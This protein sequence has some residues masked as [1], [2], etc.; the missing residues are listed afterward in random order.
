MHKIIRKS[1]SFTDGAGAELAADINA[2]IG[3]ATTTA[4]NTSKNHIH[5]GNSGAVKFIGT[6]KTAAN[7]DMTHQR[8]PA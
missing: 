7:I 2:A 1:I 5:N 4:R 3:P 6:G 8:R